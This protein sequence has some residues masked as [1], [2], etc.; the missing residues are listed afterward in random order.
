MQ[1]PT[2]VSCSPTQNYLDLLLDITNNVYGN[3]SS[4][5]AIWA[6]ISILAI[7]NNSSI[8]TRLRVQPKNGHVSFST[9]Y[10]FSNAQNF[11]HSTSSHTKSSDAENRYHLKYL[12]NIYSQNFWMYKHLGIELRRLAVELS[13]SHKF[14]FKTLKAYKL[15]IFKISRLIDF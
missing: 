4:A 11:N 6:Y 2:T 15:L 12:V 3:F 1:I 14:D 8:N 13:I 5:H 9:L 10:T 7:I